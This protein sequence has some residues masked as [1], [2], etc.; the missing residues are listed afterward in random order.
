[1]LP[2]PFASRLRFQS[3]LSH[4]VAHAEKGHLSLGHQ[5]FLAKNCD[6]NFDVAADERGEEQEEGRA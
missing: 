6:G 5:G 3:G 4:D 2:A 1:V